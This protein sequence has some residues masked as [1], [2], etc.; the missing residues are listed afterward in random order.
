MTTIKS[1]NEKKNRIKFSTAVIGAAIASGSFMTPT[2]AYACGVCAPLSM[3][4]E[5]S[6]QSISSAMTVSTTRI[7]LAIQSSTE[8]IV[9]V[10]EKN[11]AAS[12][13]LKQASLNY[14]AANIVQEAVV[15]GQ[16]KFTSEQSKPYRVC[17]Q[18]KQAANLRSVVDH[19]YDAVKT[20]AAK[21]TMK[22]LYPK[23]PGESIDEV[24]EKWDS[25]Y[26]TQ[27]DVDQGNCTTTVAKP[28]IQAAAVR[29]DVLLQPTANLTYSKEEDEAAGDFIEMVSEPIPNHDLPTSMEKTESGKAFRVAQM[30]AKGQMSVATTSLEAVRASKRSFSATPAN[31][32]GYTGDMSMLGLMKKF[33]D[34]K[35]G[36]AKYKEILQVKNKNGLL[37]ELSVQLAFSNWVD[38]HTYVQNERIEAILATQLANA[39]KKHADATLSLARAP[40]AR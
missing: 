16:E 40:A 19:S 12:K 39:A 30:T 25:K 27:I 32:A 7:K 18:V 23:K 4:I 3:M 31:A 17:E 9:G 28:V 34:E 10:N 20:D 8:S 6:T 15:E 26:C 13:E 5:A 36:N 14:D 11:Q 2:P 35:F 24:L 29:A 38:F 37:K 1:I 33:T 22:S 21:R